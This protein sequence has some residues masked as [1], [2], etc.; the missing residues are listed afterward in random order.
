M[1]S[2]TKI[3]KNFEKFF[4]ILYAILLKDCNNIGLDKRYYLF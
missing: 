3:K 4:G 1:K 2:K